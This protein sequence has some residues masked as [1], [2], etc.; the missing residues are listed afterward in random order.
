MKYTLESIPGAARVAIFLALLAA[1]TFLVL[2]D[3]DYDFLAGLLGGLLFG[4]LLGE[5]ALYLKRKR[6]R[7][8]R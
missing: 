2:T 5:W 8:K 6:T 3:T 1:L 7:Q 4:L